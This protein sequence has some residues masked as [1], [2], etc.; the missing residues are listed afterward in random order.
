MHSALSAGTEDSTAKGFA[1]LRKPRPDYSRI[2]QKLE[3]MVGMTPE[4]ASA[5]E[6]LVHSQR[7]A[8]R[9]HSGYAILSSDLWPP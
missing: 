8:E 9:T 1:M 4:K 6:T 7:A 5:Q 2:R 3:H